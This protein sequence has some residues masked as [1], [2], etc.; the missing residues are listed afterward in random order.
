MEKEKKLSQYEA[1]EKLIA[2][3]KEGSFD[4]VKKALKAGADVNA[5]DE[6]GLTAAHYAVAYRHGLIKAVKLIYANGADPE[7]KDKNGKTAY[8]YVKSANDKEGIEALEIIA[9]M[10]VEKLNKVIAD[11]QKKLRRHDG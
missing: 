11:A 3:I 9:K 7:I 5:Q 8:D 4:D 2:A 10:R 1:T 6:Y